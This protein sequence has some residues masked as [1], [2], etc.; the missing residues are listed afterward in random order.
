M[1]KPKFTPDPVP[2]GMDPQLAEYL[3]RQLNRIEDWWPKDF[4]ERIQT[5]EE[6]SPYCTG[7][8]PIVDYSNISFESASEV[9]TAVYPEPQG[10]AWVDTACISN[11]KFKDS[12]ADTYA[13][14]ANH[15]QENIGN[16]PCWV[17]TIKLYM[18]VRYVDFTYPDL[19][20]GTGYFWRGNISIPA[21][22]L[23]FLDDANSQA[24]I[25]GGYNLG[26]HSVYYNPLGDEVS[27]IT[28][29]QYGALSNKGTDTNSYGTSQYDGSDPVPTI[30]PYGNIIEVSAGVGNLRT[31]INNA[32]DGD[33]LILKS[34]I[35]VVDSVGGNGIII[36]KNIRIYGE[37]EDP[38]DV[39][40]TNDSSF[41]DWAAS[42]ALLLW[43]V[44][45]ASPVRSASDD[46]TT[47]V[48]TV[49]SYVS[50][51]GFMPG[52]YHVTYDTSPH[53]GIRVCFN[54]WLYGYY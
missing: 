41:A 29:S 16:H 9:I 13:P 39:V 32:N 21:R 47:C 5:L 33:I 26:Y 22:Q 37:T 49:G 19:G 44:S 50:G 3:S 23:D 43:Y 45:A 18:C 24:I 36:K 53:A 38:D 40:I 15:C 28:L 17:G 10:H 54:R 2:D 25:S 42:R 12:E 30:N 48:N 35:H 31:A 27:R 52:I 34:G 11:C 51:S 14:V 20:N 7:T 8:W 4:E 1:T 6:L 46:L